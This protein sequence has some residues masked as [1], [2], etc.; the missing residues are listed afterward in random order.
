[1]HD[2]HDAD[3]YANEDDDDEDNVNAMK[4]HANR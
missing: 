1:M 2:A 4:K 3:E